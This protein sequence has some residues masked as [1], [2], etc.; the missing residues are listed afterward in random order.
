MPQVNEVHIDAALTNLSVAYRNPAYISDLLAPV[1]AVRKQ[2]DRYYI[3]DAERENFRAA[4]DR[5]APGA[6]ANE[7]DFALSND[8]YSCDDHALVGVI[9]D[10]E[11]DNADPPIQ[12]NIDRTEALRDRIDLNKEIELAAMVTDTSIITQSETLAGNDQ[13]SDYVNSDPIKAVEEKKGIVI[14]SAQVMPNT[15]VLSYEVYSKVRLHPAVVDRAQLATT[16][17]V[18]PETLARIFDVEQVLV[19]RALK[20]TA[21]AGQAPAME[22]VWGKD[23]LLCYVPRR[24]ALKQTALA[25]TFQWGGAPGSLGGHIVEMWREDRRKADV[26][27][28]QRYYDQKIIAAGAAYLWKAA[29]A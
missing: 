19:P 2:F 23:A 6:E 29:V 12:P 21:A 22:F 10:E 24:A 18:G 17:L 26:I 4:N 25:Y 9:P 20:N 13:W 27:R 5:R 1:V 8:T 7:V 11:R 16:G 3:Y 14:E 28:V 15:L